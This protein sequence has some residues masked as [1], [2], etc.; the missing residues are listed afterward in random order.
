MHH[1]SFGPADAKF[2][3]DDLAEFALD[4][5]QAGDHWG[6]ATLHLA[7]VALLSYVT[8]PPTPDRNP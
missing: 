1:P 7:A 4:L 5:A 3:A 6:G 8:G 2:L